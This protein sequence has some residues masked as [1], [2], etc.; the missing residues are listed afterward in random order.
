MMQ[1]ANL[2]AGQG[3]RTGIARA[4]H[5][6]LVVGLF[7]AGSF[8]AAHSLPAQSGS[9]QALDREFKEAV[10]AYDAGRYADAAK[11]LEALQPRAPES[12]ELHELLGLAYGAQSEDAKAVEQ[13]SI[14]A[15]LRPN[16]APA[17]AN[18]AASL[19]RAG[20]ADQAESEA[21]KARALEPYSY[22]ANHNLAEL[23][24]RAN[25]IADALP[26]LEEAQR[27]RPSAY[28][29]G[30]DLAL[31]CLLTGRLDEARQRVGDLTRRKDTGELHNLLGRIDEK[32]GKFL[33]AAN[34]FAA[35]AHMDPS[36]DNLFVW[37]SELLLH[38][39]YVP[40]I[41]VFQQGT[42]R[43]P[44]S[45]RLWIGLGMALYSRGE[46]EKSIRALLAGADL[47]PADARCY[48]FL[49]KA[50]LSSPKQ[51]QDVIARF[52]RYAELQPGNARAQ[53]YYALSLWKGGRMENPTVDYPMVEA[54]LRESIALDGTMA[55]T[56]LQLGILYNDQHEY[57]QALPEYERALALNANLPDAHYRLGQYYVHAGD[58]AKA[59]GEFDVF[60]KLQAAHQAEVD[61]ERAEVQQFV[62]SAK[63][64]PATNP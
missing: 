22:D 15:R 31:A 50:Y 37:A 17:R 23:Y 26:L 30:Y 33:D 42:E 62:V 7:L 34:E 1:F 13:L 38:R 36:E 25:R 19:A 47:D 32:Q 55:D 10:A 18:L 61:K 41:E 59:Q 27:A 44:G 49:S 48:L 8:A 58:K 45:A 11:R 64:A 28:D 29:N 12:F 5:A 35:A 40:A 39:T 54:K 16:S 52:K 24:I 21:R 60:K 9:A 14:A 2:R 63:A 46:Y 4:R 57:A 53:Y 20:K 6:Y 3:S 51:A 56:H 43:Y